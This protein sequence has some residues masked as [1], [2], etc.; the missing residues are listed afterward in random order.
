MMAATGQLIDLQCKVLQQIFDLGNQ[1]K[2]TCSGKTA[3]NGCR[4]HYF[5]AKMIKV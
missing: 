4:C 1:Q 3:Y 5:S 2:W